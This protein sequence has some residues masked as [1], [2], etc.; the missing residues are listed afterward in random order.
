VDLRFPEIRLENIASDTDAGVLLA[1]L[2]GRCVRATLLAV[3]QHG[4]RVLPET[5]ISGLELGLE[6][7]GKVGVRVVGTVTA[8]VGGT[9][10]EIVGGVLKGVGGT[11]VDGING[12][13]GGEDDD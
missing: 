8:T 6:G 13:L 10:V 3:V 11:V 2:L 9:V 1:P 5:M 7:F 12:L 4:P